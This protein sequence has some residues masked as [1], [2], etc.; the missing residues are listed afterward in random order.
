MAINV[1]TKGQEGEREIAKILNGIV[2][3]VRISL[4]LPVYETNDE[5]FQRNQNQSAVGGAD[6]SNPMGLEIEIKRQEQLS[7]NTW[8]KQCVTSADRTKGI[9][10]LM[11][12]QNRKAWRICM[13]AEI[14]LQAAGSSSYSSLGPCRVEI[15]L[16]TFKAWFKSYY[17]KWV[18]SHG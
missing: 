4:K 16:D 7:V 3:D 12:R 14:P 2:R 6:L 11:F 15:D 17:T 8:W 10:I 18:G 5:L 13:E 1:R 9:P